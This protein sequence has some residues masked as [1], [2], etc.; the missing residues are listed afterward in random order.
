M[1]HSLDEAVAGEIRAGLA[2][3][4][5]TAA[6]LAAQLGV[7]AHTAGARLRGKPGFSVLELELAADLVG[8]TSVE[9][10]RRA[11]AAASQMAVAS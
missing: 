9:V 10:L 2:R 8:E 4:G 5:K 7:T 11:R 3:K 1:I 6:D